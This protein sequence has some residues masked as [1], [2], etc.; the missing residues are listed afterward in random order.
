MKTYL[1]VL[2]SPQMPEDIG[3]I[4][5]Q[6]K[7]REYIEREKGKAWYFVVVGL[8]VALIAYAVLTTNVLFAVILVLAVFT[9]VFQNLQPA[10][11]IPVVIGEDG[12]IVDK[13]FYPYKMLKSFWLIYDPPE[14]KYLYLDFKSSVRKSLAIPLEDANPLE[15]REALLNFIEEDL[16]HEEEELDEILARMF[17][18]R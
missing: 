12:I 9:I 6:W 5:I 1:K 16:Q 14:I 18:V 7:F 2:F 13:S 11:E 3:N 8:L 15:L 4:A 17:H 10:R